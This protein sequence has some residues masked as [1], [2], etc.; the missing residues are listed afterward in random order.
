ML[1]KHFIPVRLWIRNPTP[2]TR[3]TAASTMPAIPPGDSSELVGPRV[4]CD[5]GTVVGIAVG[6]EVG[7]LVG[8]S[9]G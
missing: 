1:Q 8:I 7:S 3:A 5:V 4:G 2:R 9:A 6:C